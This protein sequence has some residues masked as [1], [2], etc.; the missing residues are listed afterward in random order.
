MAN[1]LRPVIDFMTPAAFSIDGAAPLSSAHALMRQHRVR[2]LP[3][4]DGARLAG[5]LSM[6]D[7]HLLETLPGVDAREARVEEAMS[8]RPLVVGPGAPL[9]CV[10]AEMATRKLDAAV[11]MEGA[12]LVGVFTSTDAFRALAQL[13]HET[14]CAQ[15]AFHVT[16]EASLT[17]VLVAAPN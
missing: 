10:A 2:Q 16:L 12:R 7:M 4:L 6:D 15:P 5:L 11:V 3:V 9:E 14:A 1:E 13:C 17:Q 8:P